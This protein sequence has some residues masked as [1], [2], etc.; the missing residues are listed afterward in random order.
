[1]KWKIYFDNPLKSFYDENNIDRASKKNNFIIFEENDELLEFVPLTYNVKIDFS[2]GYK[3]II[4]NEEQY[5]SKFLKYNKI[6][7]YNVKKIC[8]AI[9]YINTESSSAF[10][11]N[12]SNYIDIKKLNNSH[13]DCR[14]VTVLFE[15]N[16]DNI[17]IL[18]EYGYF[19]YSIWYELS[20][21]DRKTV[22]TKQEFENKLSEIKVTNK[23]P[24]LLLHSCCGPCSSECLRQLYPYFNITIFYYN[25]NIQPFDE[26]SKRL[27]DQRR[28]IDCLGY[29]INIIERKYDYNEYL[30]IVKEIDDETEGSIRCFKCYEF[31]LEECAKLAKVNNYD[32]FTTTLSI[33]PYKNSN[34]INEIGIKLQ[35]K[36]DCS[37]LYSNFKLNDGYKKSIELS[38]KFNLYR[39]DYCGCEFSMK[40][41]K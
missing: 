20:L 10:Q 18:K 38:K 41:K 9:K 3:R 27:E 34:K 33:S 22:N 5:K 31:R 25:P 2:V 7:C 14:F 36:Y 39:Q 26:Y 13:S 1:M 32:Y 19:D 11:Y 16:E 8:K 6:F 23:K 4:L 28:I 21:I 37:F 40:F 30:E 35:E 29:D 15:F 12:M 24:K 17:N